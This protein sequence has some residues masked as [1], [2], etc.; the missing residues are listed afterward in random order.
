MYPYVCIVGV[1]RARKR[2][3]YQLT[4]Y[5]DITMLH[6]GC[7]EDDLRVLLSYTREWNTNSRTCHAAQA[8]LRVVLT[9]V[10][11]DTLVG[12]Q[13]AADLLA[14]LEAYGQRHHARLE[15]LQQ[16]SCVLDYMLGSMGVLDGAGEVEEEASQ[17]ATPEPVQ[18][19][20]ST[21]R[22]EVKKS[23]KAKKKLKA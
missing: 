23:K 8:L 22:V 5:R 3:S 7:G 15:R 14:G 11:M 17:V 2:V 6:P 12:L 9:V 13:G 10:P 21:A 18:E 19:R 4:R 16:A 20:R 1:L